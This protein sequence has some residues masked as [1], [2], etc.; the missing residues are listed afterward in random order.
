MRHFTIAELTRTGTGLPNAPTPAVTAALT[1]L[2]DRV[3][4]PLRDHLGRAVRV[5]SGY[6]SPAVNAKVGGARRSQHMRGE[7][8]DISAAGMTP[9]SLA[10]AIVALGLPFDQ[11]IVEPTWVHVSHRANNRG[12][13]LQKTATGYARYMA[14]HLEVA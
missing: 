6:R 12:E 5:T 2:V 1:A 7:A 11:I 13:T 4:D 9:E 14:Q 10:S 3:L 8:A